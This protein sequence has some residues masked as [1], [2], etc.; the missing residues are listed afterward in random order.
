MGK[1]AFFPSGHN[2]G[3]PATI[4]CRNLPEDL[5]AFHDS[6]GCPEPDNDNDSFPDA[7]DDCPGTDDV[8]GADG[9]LGPPEDF[10]HNGIQDSESAFTSD[11]SVDTFEDFDG[12][13]DTDGC[14]D[15]PGDDFDG[16]G[17]TD[18]AEVL[19]IGSDPRDGC[20]DGPTDDA[21]PADLNNDT[22]FTSADLSLIAG[23]IGQAAP[24]APARRDIAPATPDGF[25][26][27]ADLSQVAARIGTSC[28]P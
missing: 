1:T 5:D 15:S 19:S 13:I 24:P 12:V 18:D 28:A 9:A 17:F 4:D 23:V 8:A 11:D 20:A 26:T 7:I 21:N 14:H 10:N 25:I 16:D 3:D 6:D 27:S 22:F 2:H